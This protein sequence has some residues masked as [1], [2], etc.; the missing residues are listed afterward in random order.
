MNKILT[1]IN[2][3]LWQSRSQVTGKQGCGNGGST[4]MHQK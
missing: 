2:L 1:F 4:H 3:G